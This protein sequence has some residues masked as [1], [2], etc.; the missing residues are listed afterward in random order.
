MQPLG[1]NIFYRSVLYDVFTKSPGVGPRV[2]G[3]YGAE[4]GTSYSRT[5]AARGA[6]TMGKHGIIIQFFSHI[7]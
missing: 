2:R 7:E 4:S 3:M 1:G 6:G 5:A